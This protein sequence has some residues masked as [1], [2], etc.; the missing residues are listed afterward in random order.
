MDDPRGI[1]HSLLMCVYDGNIDGVRDLIIN[2]GANINHVWEGDV[3][4]GIWPGDTALRLAIRGSQRLKSN[5]DCWVNMVNE[6]LALGADANATVNIIF[7]AMRA[8]DEG[9]NPDLVAAL[10]AAGADVQANRYDLGTPLHAVCSILDP[11]KAVAV[12]NLL[13]SKGAL[14]DAKTKCGY[15]PLDYALRVSYSDGSRMP[16]KL[17]ARNRALAKCLLRAGASTDL[18]YDLEETPAETLV[19]LVIKRGGW[20]EYALWR[21]QVLVGL[22]TKC[23]PMPDDA[24]GL[25]VDFYC[26]SG[27]S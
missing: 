4:D 22:V 9:A 2:G 19:E 10:V 20:K 21:K 17:L 6:L 5:G 18:A 24:A 12:A 27:G 26:P 14:V 16:A 11:K 15:R 8:V 13:I 3:I 7:S 23:Q 25:V 1:Q